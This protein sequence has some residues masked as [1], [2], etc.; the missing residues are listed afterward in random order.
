LARLAPS[1][2]DDFSLVDNVS[3]IVVD[4]ETRATAYDAVNVDGLTARTTYEMVMIIVNSL[5]VT[6]GRSCGLNSSDDCP[7]GEHRQGV[8]DGLARDCSDLS[9]NH[10]LHLISGAMWSF[11]HCTKDGKTLGSYLDTRTAKKVF[12]IDVLNAV[13]EIYGSPKFG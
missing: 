12:V 3:V 13:H 2:E 1:P 7:F 9:T 5:L 10:T 11:C 6:C 8:V 4:L